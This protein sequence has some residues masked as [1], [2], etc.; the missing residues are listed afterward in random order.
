M[1]NVSISDV[2]SIGD[3]K[4]DKFSISDVDIDC[5]SDEA[6]TF[7]QDN[8]R[9]AKFLCTYYIFCILS[10]LSL[11]CP[12]AYMDISSPQQYNNIIVM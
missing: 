10:D 2:D 5:P 7:V 3:I 12:V 9:F 4:E 8:Q 1:E 6:V 11:H